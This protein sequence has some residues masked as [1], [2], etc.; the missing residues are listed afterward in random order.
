MFRSRS[1]GIALSWGVAA[2]V[3]QAGNGLQPPS[4]EALWPSLQAR[5]TV[6]ASSLPAFGLAGLVGPAP[7]AALA[8]QP[9]GGVRGGAVFGDY[10]FARPGFGQF[11]ATSGLLFGA[12]A[13]TP[14][15]AGGAG[16]RLGLAVSS[17]A[18]TAVAGTDAWPTVPYLGL[19]FTSQA[20][21]GGWS[22]SADLGLVAESATSGGLRRALGVQGIDN[23]VRELRLSPVLQL[24]WRY[25]F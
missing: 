21:S 1:I 22:L 11:R 4:S 12:Q 17:A 14:Q 7:T 10:Y 24:G 6:Q 25:R 8:G 13:G 15:W 9:T 18:P 23:A 20:A 5:I 3:A 19:G 2:A 16:T